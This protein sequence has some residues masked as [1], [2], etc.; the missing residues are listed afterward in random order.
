M[1]AAK[2]Y[3]ITAFTGK[4]DHYDYLKTLGAT[5]FINRHEIEMSGRPL[6]KAIWGGA[7][8]SVGD[9]TLAW[10][11][12]TVKPFGNIASIG[13]HRRQLHNFQH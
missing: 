2:G 13:F 9:K 10:L 6:D 5:E 7:V 3:E 1:L 8:D 11:C 4:T 12:A